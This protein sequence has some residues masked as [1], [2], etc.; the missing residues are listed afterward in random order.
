MAKVGA[1]GLRALLRIP[2]RSGAMVVVLRSDGVWLVRD[3]Y[4]RYKDWSSVLPPVD[5]D[6]PEGILATLDRLRKNGFQV[7]PVDTAQLLQQIRQGRLRVNVR[8]QVLA[9]RSILNNKSRI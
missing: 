7:P 9:A 5:P 2:H 4:G 1:W 3:A 6:H 8:R